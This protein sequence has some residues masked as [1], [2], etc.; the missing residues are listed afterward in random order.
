[1]TRS[2]RDTTSICPSAPSPVVLVSIP[3]PGAGPEVVESLVTKPVED[4]VAGLP[5]LDKITSFSSEGL[6]NV[7]VQFKD[8]AQ[9]T[10]RRRVLRTEIDCK[11]AQILFVHGQAFGSAFSSPGSG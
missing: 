1:M 5:N 2:A 10:M 4:A 11:I 8:E 7:T 9:H 6:S 3:Y